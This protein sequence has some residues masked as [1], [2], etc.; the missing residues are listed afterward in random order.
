MGISFCLLF[1][2]A[3]MNTEQHR[4]HHGPVHSVSFAPDGETYASGYVILI[5]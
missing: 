5:S 4:G 1:L 3:N 2:F